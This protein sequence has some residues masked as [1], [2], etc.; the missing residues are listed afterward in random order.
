MRHIATQP[1]QKVIRELDRISQQIRVEEREMVMYE[2]KIQTQHREFPID[3]VW[4]ITF[5]E[6][7]HSGEGLMYLHTTK[8]VFPYTVSEPPRNFIA[9]YKQLT[10]ADS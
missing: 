5:R 6:L 4:D 9:S 10:G 3:Q 2:E 8:G 1:Y 7:G